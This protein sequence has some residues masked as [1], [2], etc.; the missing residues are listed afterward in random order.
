MFDHC[1]ICNSKC[2]IKLDEKSII[3]EMTNWLNEG[4]IEEYAKYYYP[5]KMITCESNLKVNH[6]FKF[7][8][9]GHII[10]FVFDNAIFK[11]DWAEQ[12]EP[13]FLLFN[14]VKYFLNKN[15][16]DKLFKANSQKKV[17]KLVND[18][19]KENIFK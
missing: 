19:L 15:Q 8:D 1:P 9:D 14:D 18:I 17:D 16:K 7:V 11:M 4:N 6:K 13:T 5:Y 3:A 2:N 12:N 10:D